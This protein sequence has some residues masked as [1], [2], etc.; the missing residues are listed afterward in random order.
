MGANLAYFVF[1]A[2]LCVA[3]A[4]IALFYYRRDRKERVEGPKYRMLEDDDDRR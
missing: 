2:T 4:A 1:G 3:L